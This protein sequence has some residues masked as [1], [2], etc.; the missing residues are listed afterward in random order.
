MSWWF[1]GA[2]V[3][4]GVSAI[5]QGD[6]Q[7]RSLHYSQDVARQNAKAAADQAN[8][9]EDAQRRLGAIALGR[10][11]AGA[12]EGSGLSGTNLDVFK[13]SAQAAEMDALNIRYQGALGVNSSTAQAE[14]DGMSASN[15]NSAG[16]L[17]AAAGALSSY[18]SYKRGTIKTTQGL[19]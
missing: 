18:G 6:A 12:A 7:R 13:Q 3:V 17:N 16:Y 8:V 2:A 15:A 19:S 14:L 9:N 4:S 11:A 1:V 10:Q 5:A